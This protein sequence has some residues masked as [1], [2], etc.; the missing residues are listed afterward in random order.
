M[1][2]LESDVPSDFS[3]I[4][5]ATARNVIPRNILRNILYNVSGL[6]TVIL[7]PRGEARLHRIV[8]NVL[9]FTQFV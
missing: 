8:A 6:W 2:K 9:F 3:P 4:L 5:A 1:V 7:G